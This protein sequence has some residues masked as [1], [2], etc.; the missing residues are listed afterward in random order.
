MWVRKRISVELVFVSLLFLVN[1]SV[2]SASNKIHLKSRRLTPDKGISPAARAKIE[3]IPEKAHVL[4]QLERIPTVKERKELEEKGIKLLS[5]IPDNAWFATIPSDKTD[6]IA[7]LSDVRAINEILIDDKIAPQIKESGINEY[8]ML[9]DEKAKLVIEFFDDVSLDDASLL[10]EDYGG[11]VQG[12]GRI[13]NA[14]VVHLPIDSIAGLADEDSVQWLDQH[15]EPT[16]DNDG[17]RAAIG[18][19]YVQASPY[20]LNGV[21]VNIGQWDGGCVDDTHNDLKTADLSQTRVTHRNCGSISTHATHVAGTMI[22]NGYW[23][24]LGGEPGYDCTACFAIDPKYV[25]VVFNDIERNPDCDGEESPP[26]PNGKE[27]VLPQ[28]SGSSCMWNESFFRSADVDYPY[29]G[30]WYVEYRARWGDKT[31]LILHWHVSDW[32]D[33]YIFRYEESP[34]CK[35]SGMNNIYPLEGWSSC[36]WYGTAE[37][38]LLQ[39]PAGD[40]CQWKGMATKANVISYLWWDDVIDI[41]SDYDEAV[42]T[43]NIDISQN[44]WG[45]GHGG[46]Y[47]AA[48]KAYDE[49]IHGKFSKPII[50]V[51]SAGNQGPNWYTVRIPNSAKNTIEV[52]ATNSDDDTLYFNPST[53]KGSSRGP[54]A[55]GRIK[56]DVVA[57]GDEVGGDGGIVSTIPGNTYGVLSGTSMAAPAVSGGVALMLQYWRQTHTEE[58]NVLPSTIKAILMQTAKDLGNTGPDY[59]F[60]YGLIDVN[61]AIKLIERDTEDNNDVIFEGSIDDQYD[62]DPF[63]IKVPAGENK[64]KL[65]LVWDDEPGTTNASKHLINDLDLIV[66]DPCGVRH[67]PWTLD[68]TDGNEGNPAVRTQEDHLNN[69]EQV[70]VN[71]PVSGLWTVE[72]NGPNVPVAPQ[73]YSLVSNF[74]ECFPSCDPNYNGWV[75]LGKPT[76]WC[77]QRQCHGD[78][79]NAQDGDTKQ[80]YYYVYG[81]DLAEVIAG[82]KKVYS[83]DPQVDT[84]IC[85]DFTHREA[86][87]TKQGYFRVYGDDL[88]VVVANWKTNPDPNC[89]DCSEGL[90]AGFSPESKEYSIEELLQWLDEIWA[91]EQVREQISEEDLQKLIDSLKEQSQN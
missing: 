16:L 61:E 29:D 25:K 1:I 22:G 10:V 45:T 7:G 76:C 71:N 79:D 56:P 41:N 51:G 15:Y 18:V 39:W 49:I 27:F 19:D 70:E 13:I 80:G 20:N 90:Q 53:G 86:G 36:G 40:P 6:E 5:Y 44:S 66:K 54:A 65:T 38:T 57:P 34:N 63:I 37:V 68:P 60:G 21:D 11:V 42:N 77:Y 24:H 83:G 62:K 43:Y 17:S 75:S 74:A 47:D 35:T 59:S 4:I 32:I 46:D 12:K 87:D 84:W 23:S 3:A 14:L 52:G 82:W 50:I 2:V 55:D 78:H 88:A 91:D 28:F 73:S 9:E 72:V 81:G 8:S 64:L 58:P 89:L 48:S 31:K 85:A 69:V 30:Y 26:I 67:Y 33:T